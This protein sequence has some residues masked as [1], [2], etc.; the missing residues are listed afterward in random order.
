MRMGTILRSLIIAEL[1]LP[2]SGGKVL[3]I[4]CY[5][6]YLLSTIN[7]EKKVGIDISPVPRHS[8]IEYIQGD[9]LDYDFGEERF[10]RI[11]AMDVLEHIERDDLFLEKLVN[12][13]SEEGIAIMSVPSKNIRIFPG[14]LQNWVDKKWG[15]HYRR[16]YTKAEIEELF[17][18]TG[19]DLDIEFQTISCPIFRFV[20]LP[21]SMMWRVLPNLTSELL[22]SIVRLDLKYND[23]DSGFLYLN[24][25][26]RDKKSDSGKTL[27]RVITVVNNHQIPQNQR[28]REYS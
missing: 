16:G 23:S 9:F 22:E 21:L 12:L 17:G 24:A 2:I 28:Q 26:K 8:G 14:F 7:A 20:Y 27:K 4:G 18:N 1:Q 5:D 25:Y 10:D 11:L 19:H 15:R 13:L 3:D 6:G